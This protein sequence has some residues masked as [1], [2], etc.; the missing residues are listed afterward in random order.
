MGRLLGPLRGGSWAA[1]E[2]PQA[3]G[4]SRIGASGLWRACV[5]LGGLPPQ[6]WGVPKVLCCGVFTVQAVCV[7][8]RVSGSSSWLCHLVWSTVGPELACVSVHLFTYTCF[9]VSVCMWADDPPECYLGAHKDPRACVCYVCMHRHTA[10]CQN[11]TSSGVS[12]CI[13]VIY[14]RVCAKILNGYLQRLHIWVSV[15]QCIWVCTQVYLYVWLVQGRSFGCKECR[16]RVCTF[17]D[18]V[19]IEKCLLSRLDKHAAHII[20]KGENMLVCSGLI[21]IVLAALPRECYMKIL[22]ESID[23]KCSLHLSVT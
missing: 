17:P 11:L 7:K 4:S 6:G 15:W 9:S 21:S 10:A 3:S 8:P 1:T 22:F 13:C 2:C 23:V 5:L 14:M 20:D 12:S 16:C 19:W 18:E